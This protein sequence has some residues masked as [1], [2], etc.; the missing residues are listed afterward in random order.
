MVWTIIDDAGDQSII[1]I[2]NTAALILISHKLRM[3]N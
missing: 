2:V 3:V 1:N